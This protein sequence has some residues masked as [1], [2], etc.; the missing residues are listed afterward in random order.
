M[1]KNFGSARDYYRALKALEAEG[2]P[3]AHRD[4]LRAH[5]AAPD[6]T[7]SWRE[8]APSVGYPS[9]EPV[10]LQYGKFARRIAERLGVT[11]RRA[12]GFWLYVLADWGPHLDP[13]GHT[14]F[15]LRP[16]VIAALKRMGWLQG[17]AHPSL[18]ETD[19]GMI[20]GRADLRLVAHRH[21][22]AALR[23]RK[24]D[25]ALRQ[26]PDGKLRCAIPGC[27]FSFQDVY[28]EGASEFIQV[29]HVEPLGQRNRP[30]PTPL[31]DLILVCA[32][33]HSMLHYLKPSRPPG[34][35]VPRRRREA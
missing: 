30:S 3:V 23:R 4:L 9:P 24:V 1:I 32:N 34:R 26:S 6:H 11:K 13:K 15:R 12:N 29:H 18:L 5:F 25:E 17:A 8:L 16:Q 7:V 21:R 33:C 20:E 35:L 28:G 14:T 10:K 22:E 2:I 31:K 27:G 19:D